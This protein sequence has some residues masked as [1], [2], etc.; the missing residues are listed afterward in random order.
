MPR[1]QDER[2][3]IFIPT[4]DRAHWL[5]QAI[6][7]ALNQ[8]YDRYSVVVADNASSDRTAEVV[9]S[10]SS[11][12]L[13]YV[14]RDHNIRLLPNLNACA[15]AAD[16]D[17]LA[18]VSDD[19]LLYPEFLETTVAVLDSTPRAGMVHTGFHLVD[20]D[21]AVLPG[22]TNW[23]CGL[24]A[25]AMET[26]AQ[27]LRASMEWSCRVCMSTTLLRRQAL[28][29]EV[30]RPSEFPAFDLGL[31]LRLSLDWDFAFVARPLGQFRVHGDSHS[32]QFGRPVEDGYVQNLELVRHIKRLKDGFLDAH[33]D[34]LENP[35][36]LRRLAG[37]ALRRELTLL[38]RKLTLPERR[39][40]PTVKA[41]LDLSR[42]DRRLLVDMVAW[43]MVAASALGSH[44][45]DRLKRLRDRRRVD[46][47]A[48]PAGQER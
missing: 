15:Q 34:R 29:A 3:T 16:T 27:F 23:T 35:A 11:P 36:Q 48:L 28:P 22:E 39:L 45:V 17:Y 1:P 25:D 42:T 2:A 32:A 8:T 33:G 46:G 14:R 30:F 38:M 13:R 24:E 37:D 31:W 43:R 7:A 18:I 4:Y 19:D 9:K 20:G 6:P 12:R 10:F 47:N 5:E 41:W 26:G 21:G 44:H 40:V